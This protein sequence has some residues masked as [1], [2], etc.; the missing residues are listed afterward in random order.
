MPTYEDEAPVK[1]KFKAKYDP[2]PS[3]APANELSQEEIDAFVKG[4][5]GLTKDKGNS[6]G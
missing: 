5:L 4:V 1:F 6:S 3:D 2:P